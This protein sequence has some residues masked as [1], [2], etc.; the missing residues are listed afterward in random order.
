MV[1]RSSGDIRHS[2]TDRRELKGPLY[3]LSFVCRLGKS[4]SVM[5]VKLSAFLL[6]QF[7][8]ARVVTPVGVILKEQ[9]EPS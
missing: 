9:E 6:M 5:P 8:L 1:I 4:W 7:H 3:G 2:M